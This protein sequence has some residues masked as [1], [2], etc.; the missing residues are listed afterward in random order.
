MS[1]EMQR[2]V[3]DIDTQAVEKYNIENDSTAHINKELD[4]K[5]NP[6]WHCIVETQFRKLRRILSCII[7]T[8]C[9]QT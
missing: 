4:G 2:S 6:T 1:E 8:T 5:H 3:V 7:A 9:F